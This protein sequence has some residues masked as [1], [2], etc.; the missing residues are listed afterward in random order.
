MG[1]LTEKLNVLLN[2]M[3]S[4]LAKI[5]AVENKRQADFEAFLIKVNKNIA[6]LKENI[7][8]L[9]AQI[10][11]NTECVA[12]ETAVINEATAKSTRNADLKEKA[13]KMCAKFV[14]EVKQAQEARRIEVG[15]VRQVLG[16]MKVRFG[17]VP[18]RLTDYLD[19]VEKGFAEYENKTKLIAY[20]VYKYMAL[21]EINSER[22]SL[23]TN[24]TMSTTK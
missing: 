24:K 23:L 10:Q 19:S 4:D 5:T 18:E 2:T 8:R 16:L 17:N 14:E 13:T 7:D 20:K 1:T 9:D 21:N 22:I 3:V 15:V 12:R 11:S 6:D